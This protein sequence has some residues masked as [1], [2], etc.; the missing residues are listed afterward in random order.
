MLI[1]SGK[2]SIHFALVILPRNPSA[3]NSVYD[4]DHDSI[5]DFSKASSI[6]LLSNSADGPSL[7][8]ILA[9]VVKVCLANLRLMTNRHY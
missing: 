4:S 7:G 9:K 1:S 8:F 6:E 3:E 5:D 2:V